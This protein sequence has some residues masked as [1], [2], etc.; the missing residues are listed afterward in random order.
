MASDVI[1]RLAP[2]PTTT[3]IFVL[4]SQLPSIAE[5]N[6]ISVVDTTRSDP[7][8]GVG[9]SIFREM[10]LPSRIAIGASSAITCRESAS[11]CNGWNLGGAGVL[12]LE[13]SS[14]RSADLDSKLM[15]FRGRSDSSVCSLSADSVKIP[16]EFFNS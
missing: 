15:I 11:R 7:K 6:V 2:G 14:R 5:S 13:S 12:L 1:L 4:C 3:R 8:E 10:D 9:A 16:M